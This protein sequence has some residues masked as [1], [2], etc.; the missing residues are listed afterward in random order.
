[1]D[2]STST[3][4]DSSHLEVHY[5]GVYNGLTKLHSYNDGVDDSLETL[6]DVVLPNFPPHH[7]WYFHRSLGKVC[8]FLKEEDGDGNDLTYMM[9]TNQRFWNS[10]ILKFLVH[11]HTGLNSGEEFSHIIRR[12]IPSPTNDG[13]NT[14]DHHAITIVAPLD[15]QVERENWFTPSRQLLL[16]VLLDL[17]VCFTLL[18]VW[19]TKCYRQ[20]RHCFF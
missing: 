14:T 2:P 12:L 20:G 1:M 19:L 6:A 10:D 3:P 8:A 7:T 13:V 4:T 18:V 16:L 15:G 9:I 11:V 17:M 5:C